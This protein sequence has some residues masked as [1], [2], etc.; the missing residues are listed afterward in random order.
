MFSINNIANSQMFLRYLCHR[1]NKPYIL[2]MYRAKAG[3]S[4]F[5][6]G[7]KHVGELNFYKYITLNSANDN[8]GGAHYPHVLR[9][10]DKADVRVKYSKKA[11]LK[12]GLMFINLKGGYRSGL[13]LSLHV[14]GRCWYKLQI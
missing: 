13:K 8:A 12:K 3:V 6:Y 7:Y 4:W 11:V 5:V 14:I 10:K 1:Q 2:S 9:Y